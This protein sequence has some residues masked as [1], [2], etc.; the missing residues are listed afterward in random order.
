MKI[1]RRFLKN[2][3]D[4][5]Y[6]FNLTGRFTLFLF[7]ET[8]VMLLLYMTGNFQSF[9]DSSQRFILLLASVTAMALFLFSLCGFI[10]CIAYRIIKKEKG[11]V[12]LSFVYLAGA[13]FSFVI[14]FLIRILSWLSGGMQ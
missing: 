10:E 4:S 5:S 1:K 6:L 7:M 3:L 11:F 2:N 13:V 14:I 9:S 12:M 8:C